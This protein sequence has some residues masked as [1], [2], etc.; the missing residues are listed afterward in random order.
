MLKAEPK[1]EL[2]YEKTCPN[3]GPARE[4]LHTA[5]L[6]SGKTGDWI[7]WEVSNPDAPD[8]ARNYG[9]PTILIDGKDVAGEQPSENNACCRI[10]K[11]S[12]TA[13]KGIPELAV[14]LKALKESFS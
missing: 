9:S 2:I 6:R 8:Y 12:D 1:V 10:Y 4:L 14:V 5:L 7:E 3:V 11:T 13:N